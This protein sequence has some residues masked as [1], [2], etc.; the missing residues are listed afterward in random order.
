MSPMKPRLLIAEGNAEWSQV[1]ARFFAAS[2]FDVETASNG[3]ECMKKIRHTRPAVL[4]LDLQLHWGGADGVVAR[5][6]EEKHWH[7]IPV[8]LTTTANSVQ[9]YAGLLEPPVVR[10][11]EKPFPLT[12]LLDS[13]RSAA[14]DS[15]EGVIAS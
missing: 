3:L 13:V 10:C 1:Y 8:V 7:R 6:R 5:L 12:A 9:S 11:L 14:L 2:G 4:L 15:R